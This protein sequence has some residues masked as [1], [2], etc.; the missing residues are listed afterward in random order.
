M[1]H[2]IGSDPTEIIKLRTTE[3]IKEWTINKM[4]R[5][6]DANSLCFDKCGDRF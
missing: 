3:G 6:I 2:I 5:D 1:D 4:F